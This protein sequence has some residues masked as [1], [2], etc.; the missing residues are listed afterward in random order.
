MFHHTQLIT[1]QMGK[2]NNPCYSILLYLLETEKVGKVRQRNFIFRVSELEPRG[3]IIIWHPFNVV[4]VVRKVH[5]GNSRD[6]PDP[7]FKVPVNCGHDVTL[8]L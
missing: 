1:V 6:L 3:S 8:V 4:S 2:E 5:D 7:S